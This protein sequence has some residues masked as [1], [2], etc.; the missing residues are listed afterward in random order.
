MYINL[1][2]SYRLLTMKQY[3]QTKLLNINLF[4]HLSWMAKNSCVSYTPSQ[5][6]NYGS[7]STQSIR[8]CN[9]SKDASGESIHVHLV[10]VSQ[11]TPQ[12]PYF[13]EPVL[14]LPPGLV[15]EHLFYRNKL[16]S[17]ELM[18]AWFLICHCYNA[19]EDT[20]IHQKCY[21]QVL[22]FDFSQAGEIHI[23]GIFL[24][25]DAGQRQKA[26]SGSEAK[27]WSLTVER[28]AQRCIGG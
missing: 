18:M 9:N 22:N 24:S 14:P 10:V 19:L 2:R 13:R 23:H 6:M 20:W 4:S 21:F 27:I 5:R 12:I 8:S 7:K 15:N 28:V 17:R 1:V 3:S 16:M 11:Q 26:S 25:P